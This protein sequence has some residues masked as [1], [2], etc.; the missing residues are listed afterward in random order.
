[1]SLEITPMHR[2]GKTVVVDMYHRLVSEDPGLRDSTVYE[3]TRMAFRQSL[4]EQTPQFRIAPG[5][6]ILTAMKEVEERTIGAGW[7]DETS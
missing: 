6:V 1:M 3:I 2:Y 7:V 5:A 4:L